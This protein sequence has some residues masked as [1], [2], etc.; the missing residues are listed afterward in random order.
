MTKPKSKKPNP[1]M[2]QRKPPKPH[3]MYTNLHSGVLP[4][5]REDGLQFVFHPRDD[6]EN[7]ENEHETYIMGCFVC[8]NEKCRQQDWPSKKIFTVIRM[9]AGQRYNARVY[10]QRCRSC[11]TLSRPDLD[12][13]SYVDRVVYRLRKWS[14]IHVPES[15]RQWKDTREPH[16]KELC[17]GCRAGR[18]EAGREGP[19]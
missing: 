4:Q 13:E 15:H 11:N 14:G 5:L 12:V 1:R 19:K 6:D 3:S 9:Y 8:R 2:P 17:E 16:K 7:M 10:H 18:C